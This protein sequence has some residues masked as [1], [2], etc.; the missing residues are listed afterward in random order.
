MSDS[1]IVSFVG[2]TV[3]TVLAPVRVMK[4]KSYDAVFCESKKSESKEIQRMYPKNFWTEYLSFVSYPHEV[5]PNI[6]LGS[7]CNAAYY[8]SLKDL[9][10]KYIINVTAEIS[11]YYPDYFEYYR[12]PIRDDNM[13]S[14]QPY[15][16]ES[17]DKIDSFLAKGDGKV[18]IH[19]F[20]G[21]SR[22]ATIAAWYISKKT[23]DDITTVLVN[24]KNQR[25]V[26]NL[27]DQYVK[28]LREE[29]FK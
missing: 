19:C 4:D 16:Q 7:A 5:Y 28:D 17:Y 3:N 20:M 26:V 23:G 10:I 11:D 15:L 27:T 18:F 9:G 6:I 12:I 1:S 21:A 24:L 29:K 8:Y 13:E 14:I 2:R 22:S 25:P